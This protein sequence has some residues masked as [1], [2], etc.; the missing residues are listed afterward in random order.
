M[1]AA[2]DMANE[3]DIN[4]WVSVNGYPTLRFYLDGVEF[5]YEGDRKGEDIVEFMDKVRATTLDKAESVEKL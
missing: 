5:D 3:K 1:I 4:D 2:V